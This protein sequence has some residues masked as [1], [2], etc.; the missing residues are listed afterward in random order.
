MLILLFK[1]KGFYG[2]CGLRGGY[3]EIFNIPL[4][5][6]AELY[7]LCSI[8]LCSNTVGQVA[9]G[10]MVQPP[11]PGDVSYATYKAER[12]GILASLRRRAGLLSKAL[13]A[14]EGVSCN[15][16]DGALYA[17]PTITIPGKICSKFMYTMTTFDTYARTHTTLP[18]L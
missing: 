8:S 11:Q 6:K 7:K 3:F 16:I 18:N 10:L 4:D 9:T 14:M 17:F 5:V 12:D 15:S 13:N 2:E 1:L